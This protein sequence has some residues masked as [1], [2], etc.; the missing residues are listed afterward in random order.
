MLNQ[1]FKVSSGTR[2]QFLV[3]AVKISSIFGL[4]NFTRECRKIVQ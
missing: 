3:D 2:Q 1:V 4:S